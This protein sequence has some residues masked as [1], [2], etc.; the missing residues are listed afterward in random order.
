MRI[1]PLTLGIAS[2]ITAAI[3]WLFCSFLVFILPEMMMKMT[4]AMVH[5][6]LSTM[7]WTLTL[8]N[9]LVGLISWSIS[10]GVTGWILAYIYNMLVKD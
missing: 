5:A 3:L 8:S 7:N 4:G 10:A 1:K 9:V 2:A 6:D